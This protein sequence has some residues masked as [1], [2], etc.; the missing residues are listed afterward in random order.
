MGFCYANAINV[1]PAFLIGTPV[2]LCIYPEVQVLAQNRSAVAA[3]LRL[4]TDL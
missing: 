4:E 3:A 1:Q 2:F